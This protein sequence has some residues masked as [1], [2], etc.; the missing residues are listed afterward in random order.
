MQEL[1]FDQAKEV[2]G[3]LPIIPVA[4]GAYKLVK[5]GSAA[6]AAGYLAQKGAN[7]ANAEDSASEE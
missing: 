3:G 2:S 1:T 5:W 7:R 6:Y 4:M